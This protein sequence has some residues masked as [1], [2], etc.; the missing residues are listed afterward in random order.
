MSIEKLSETLRELNLSEKESN[1]QKAA[2][3]LGSK[4][5]RNEGRMSC[6]GISMR[7]YVLVCLWYEM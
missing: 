1:G 7:G 6:V 2:T 4:I 3:V 5:L